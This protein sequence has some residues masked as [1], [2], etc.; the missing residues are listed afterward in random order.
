MRPPI[1]L[2][3]LLLLLSA[4]ACRDSEGPVDQAQIY[5]RLG[6][7][8]PL[9]KHAG[10]KVTL[11]GRLSKVPWQHMIRWPEGYTEMYYF[12]FEL[13]QQTVLYAKT[14]IDCPNALTVWGQVVEI[15]G[16]SKRPGS[17][18]P[19]VEHHLIIDRWQCGK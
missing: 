4:A 10:A 1:V 16:E 2:L 15:R 12:D 13:G 14:P 17:D 18:A 6:F 8:E 3:G 11:E 7:N 9:S 19:V 5:L